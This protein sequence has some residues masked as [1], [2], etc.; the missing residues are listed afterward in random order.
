MKSTENRLEPKGD[1]IKEKLPTLVNI[2][3]VLGSLGL[4]GSIYVNGLVFR[5]WGIN[6][7]DVASPTDLVLS[8]ANIISICVMML[9][10]IVLGSYP[11]SLMNNLLFRIIS[12][13]DSAIKPIA[14][15]LI[16]YTI[17][18]FVVALPLLS[19]S[20]PEHIPDII[21]TFYESNNKLPAW[22]M[23]VGYVLIF[24]FSFYFL[25]ISLKHQSRIFRRIGAIS[26]SWQFPIVLGFLSATTFT[27][28]YAF[29]A[30]PKWE[31][32]GVQH[33]CKSQLIALWIGSETVVARCDDAK[34]RVVD[35]K[36]YMMI[37]RDGLKFH[38]IAKPQL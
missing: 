21:F 26:R 11:L 16:P 22:Y 8:G 9:M 10:I 30:V 25:L 14:I 34:S 33:N 15:D 4:I 3:T 38:S 1:S 12:S 6:F 13:G 28:I 2:V 19:L 18:T 20:F 31:I 27:C 32:A 7:F 37:P 35:S 5:I 17:L 29:L 36:H 24:V 23:L